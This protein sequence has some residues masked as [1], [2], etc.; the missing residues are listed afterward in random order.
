MTEVLLGI[1]LGTSGAKAGLYTPEGALLG[2][3]RS[4]AYGMSSPRPGWSE[5]DPEGWWLAV[6]ESLGGACRAAGVGPEAVAA[7]GLSVFF[8]A[9]VTLSDSGRP[10]RPA[11]LY[12]DQRSLEQ[13]A[14]VEASFAPGEYRRL[15]GNGASPG[16]CAATSI[17]WLMESEPELY[18]SAD[19]VGFAN[20][21]L[22]H[23]LTGARATDFTHSG[24]S[25]LIDIRRLDR[26][27]GGICS[28]LG[29]DRA[30]LP[31][32]VPAGEVVGR[33]T[34]RAAAETGLLEGTS[35]VCGTG[36]APC[37]SFGA[38]SILP[39]TVAYVAGSTDCVTMPLTEP[40]VDHPWLTMGWIK[41]G[42]WLG[43]G[44]MTSAGMAVEWFAE[45]FYP[46][47]A[48][49]RLRSMTAEA[50]AAE[51]ADLLFLPYLQG[52]RTPVWDPMARGLFTGLALSTTRGQ[53][54]RAVFEGTAFGL[55]DV[56][57]CL[58]ERSSGSVTEIRAGGGPLRNLF[59]TQL[60]ADALG[61]P[62]EVLGFQET[63]SLGAALLAATARGRYASL[64]EAA[65][66]ARRAVPTSI[67]EP[68]PH[69]A[70]LSERFARYRA[71]YP[72]T[73][74][75]MHVLSSGR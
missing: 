14:A 25:G 71:L 2:L 24:L 58:E 3:G 22:T 52:E 61:K 6:R 49:E 10:L 26:W 45:R 63:G 46:G 51:P 20:T 50:E 68:G 72:R 13:A 48:E 30:K 1:D 53:M 23:R 47:T 41:P 32:I 18:Q 4:A 31:D 67:V 73:R 27:D 29:V 15:S 65:D 19:L 34:R 62:L 55:R 75:L 60:K 39:G 70:A 59:W 54:A 43:I 5:S 9:V 7:V 16:T 66:A 35:V 33:V 37:G 42:L 21:F 57:G 40:L 11:I 17:R 44:T 38:G 74:E 56:I 12:N 64:E 28:R 36:D 69:A 8:P